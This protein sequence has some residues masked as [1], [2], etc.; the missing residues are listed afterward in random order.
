M[1][2]RVPT[3]NIL[4]VSLLQKNPEKLRKVYTIFGFF[5]HG[6]Y[7]R[8]RVT[9]GAGLSYVEFLVYVVLLRVIHRP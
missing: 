7:T 4:D 5:L 2:L 8:L 3:R 6:I 1:Q 9:L